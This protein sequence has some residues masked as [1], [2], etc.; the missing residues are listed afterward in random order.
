VLVIA[1]VDL[2]HDRALTFVCNRFLCKHFG[3]IRD[4][5]VLMTL[6]LYLFVSVFI[7]LSLAL[8]TSPACNNCSCN[9]NFVI[10]QTD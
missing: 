7:A 5:C 3:V 10:T 6:L 4:V 8:L 1:A 2:G 9:D